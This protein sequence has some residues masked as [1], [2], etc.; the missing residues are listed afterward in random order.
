M[1]IVCFGDSNTFGYEPGTFFSGRYEANF[2]WVDILASK[3]GWNLI[4]EGENG[5]EI[6]LRDVQIPMNGDLFIVMLGTNDLLQ[7]NSVD[8]VVDRM[9]AFLK[10]LPYQKDKILLIAPPPMVPGLWV[11]NQSLI[12]GSKQLANAYKILSV[13]AGVWF[14]DSGAWNIPMT[15]DGVH[16]TKDGHQIFA[17]C[18]YNYLTKENK[19]CLKQG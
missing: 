12:D 17:E 8:K 15:F 2:R 7:G 5:R 11:P 3:S 4:N 14:A 10:R 19:S 9:D 13:R 6:P 1:K 18:L 16:F